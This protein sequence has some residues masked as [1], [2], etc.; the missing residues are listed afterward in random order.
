MWL[1][2]LRLSQSWRVHLRFPG[3]IYK[4]S[5]DIP[6][7]TQDLFAYHI[8]TSS[9][10]L[11]PH[12][13]ATKSPDLHHAA[14]LR[15][16]STHTHTHSLSPSLSLSL[17]LSL[18]SLPLPT[19]RHI[20]RPLGLLQLLHSLIPINPRIQRPQSTSYNP[21]NRATQRK[22]PDPLHLC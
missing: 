4:R 21:H 14:L 13:L 2:T 16:L 3:H 17:S 1:K 11:R 20:L 6:R 12:H 15:F 19:H 8:H 7:I 9:Q 5:R 18:Y 22:Q 10:L